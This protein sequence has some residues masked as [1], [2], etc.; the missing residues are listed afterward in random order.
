MYIVDNNDGTMRVDHLER[1]TQ[2]CDNE[3]KRP[4]NDNIQDIWP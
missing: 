1:Y 2:K 4:P 3:L